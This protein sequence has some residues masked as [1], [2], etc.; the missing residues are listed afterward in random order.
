MLTLRYILIVI[1]AIGFA[2]LI[3]TW[4]SEHVFGLQPCILCLFQRY[5][6]IFVTVLAGL[7]AFIMPSYARPQIMVIC[8]AVLL[9]GAGVAFYQVGVEEHWFKVPYICSANL[10][11][12]TSID[13]LQDQL[14]NI[15]PAACDQ[16][17]FRL[18]GISMAG[19]NVFLSLLL[20]ILCLIRPMIKSKD[21]FFDQ[22]SI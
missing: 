11:A 12:A 7:G 5:I 3:L 13:D 2:T 1:F 9:V 18:F 10:A 15:S 21:G 4:M 19:Y 14:M 20:A 22:S 8:G 17:A 16:V 6:C